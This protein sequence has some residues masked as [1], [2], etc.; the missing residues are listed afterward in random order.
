MPEYTHSK[1]WMM[2]PTAAY[3]IFERC[4]LVKI[5]IGSDHAG[6][7]FKNHI[8]SLL[9][10]MGME[11]KDYGTFSS[12]RTDYPIYAARAAKA[13]VNKECDRGI[14]ICGTGVGISIAANKIDGI[15]AIVCSDCYSAKLSREH[16]DT[17]ILAM[18]SRVVGPD[19][20]G[21]IVKIWLET[22]YDGDRHQKRLDMISKLERNEEI[23]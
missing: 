1:N 14:L 9:E 2:K 17:N 13:V 19:L 10:E 11:V 12:D 5:A 15:R 7:D 22:E 6:L 8:K 23:E 20:A 3:N 18:G 16:N 4:T 21:M